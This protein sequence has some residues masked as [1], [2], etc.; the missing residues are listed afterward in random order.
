M[1]TAIKGET[2]CSTRTVGDSNPPH[3]LSSKGR[4]SKQ[5]IKR[6][7]MALHDILDKMDL[8]DIQRAFYPKAKYKFFF[9]C[10]WNFSRIDHMLG[11]K[12]SLGK[13]KKIDIISSIFSDHTAI[14][15]EINSACP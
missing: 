12:A 9:K 7:I 13:F 1:L 8:I 2:N 4:S 14:R 11:H 15:L 6:E 5:K 10:R 3:T